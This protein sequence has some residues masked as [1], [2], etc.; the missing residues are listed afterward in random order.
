MSDSLG[1][2]FRQVYER[3]KMESYREVVC[4]S[5]DVDASL[6]AVAVSYTHLTLPTS[7]VV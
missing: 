5:H 1:E 6:S 4:A 2:G 7:I 3:L